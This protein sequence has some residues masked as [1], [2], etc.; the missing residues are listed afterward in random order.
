MSPFCYF[1]LQHHCSAVSQKFY[2]SCVPLHWKEVYNYLEYLKA[3]YKVFHLHSNLSSANFELNWEKCRLRNS[4]PG[5]SGL[6]NAF[7]WLYEIHCQ[8]LFDHLGSKIIKRMHID[9]HPFPSF[10]RSKR[11]H[12]LLSVFD[13]QSYTG[14]ILSFSMATVCTELSLYCLWFKYIL[15]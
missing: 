15:H 4:L 11:L 14:Q 6:V 2:F 13:V 1:Y 10:V 9:M 8:C 12:S 3:I 7:G 5:T